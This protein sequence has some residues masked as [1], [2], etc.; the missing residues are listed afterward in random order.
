[1]L[2]CVWSLFWQESNVGDFYDF[3]FVSLPHKKHE[4]KE[5]VKQVGL[6]RD[7]IVNKYDQEQP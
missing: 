3:L 2:F 7:R 5:F 1:M 4:A 6:L